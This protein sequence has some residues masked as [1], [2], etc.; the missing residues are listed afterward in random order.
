MWPSMQAT[1]EAKLRAMKQR[2]DYDTFKKMVRREFSSFMRSCT[3]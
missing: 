2:V 1:N 3:H